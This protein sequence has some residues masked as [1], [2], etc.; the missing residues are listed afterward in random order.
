VGPWMMWLRP[1]GLNFLVHA[2]MLHG[3]AVT[4]FDNHS[5]KGKQITADS[6]VWAQW[7]E[8]VL[9]GTGV[10]ES[11]QHPDQ[12]PRAGATDLNQLSVWPDN[13]GDLHD[14]HPDQSRR[15]GAIDVYPLSVW[16]GN[17]D[18]LML[19]QT[20]F[21]QYVL[22]DPR[23]KIEHFRDVVGDAWEQINREDMVRNQDV[24]VLF[25]D[26]PR[27]FA[28]RNDAKDVLVGL[29]SDTSPTQLSAELLPVLRDQDDR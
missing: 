15:A 22:Q 19:L 3:V 5:S 20:E 29:P 4:P 8:N 24:R 18:D 17:S 28:Y 10:D 26:Y 27:L 1:R 2:M 13:S 16:P 12:S 9:E 7:L 11:E 23:P 25:V 6:R 21:E 14:Q